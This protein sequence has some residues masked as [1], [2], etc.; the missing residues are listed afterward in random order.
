MENRLYSVER[1]LGWRRFD[2][3]RAQAYIITD[4]GLRARSNTTQH[5]GR[6]NANHSLPKVRSQHKIIVFL[7]VSFYAFILLC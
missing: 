6:L 1:V 4:N 5:H 3:H 7:Y 2:S